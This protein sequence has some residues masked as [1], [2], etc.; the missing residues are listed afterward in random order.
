M[1]STD[2]HPRSQSQSHTTAK[3]QNA[4]R[5]AAAFSKEG[6]GGLSRRHVV[7]GL[8]GTHSTAQHSTAQHDLIAAGQV[9]PSP[10]PPPASVNECAQRHQPPGDYRPAPAP[11]P[12]R[13]GAERSGAQP[14]PPLQPSF[15]AG[16]QPVRPSDRPKGRIRISV[17]TYCR[18]SNPKPTT[19][20]AIAQP[21]QQQQ[22]TNGPTGSSETHS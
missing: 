11:P 15:T 3:R 2:A 18:S 20:R 21:Q 10:P 19:L 12:H 9:E 17:L 7:P 14:T 22:L 4:E 16:S 1:H 6:A 8:A 13:S 5:T